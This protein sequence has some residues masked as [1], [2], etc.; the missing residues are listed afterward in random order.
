MD[1]FASPRP[2]APSPTSS[3][4]RSSSSRARARTGSLT[5]ARLRAFFGGSA[6]AELRETRLRSQTHRRQLRAS[7]GVLIEELRV[8]RAR[9]TQLRDDSQAMRASSE[10]MEIEMSRDGTEEWW[11][12]IGEQL[13]LKAM[14]LDLEMRYEESYARKLRGR[15]GRIAML[16]TVITNEAMQDTGAHASE[17]RS[18]FAV[19]AHPGQPPLILKHIGQRPAALRSSKSARGRAMMARSVDA[20]CGTLD[21]VA[22]RDA[23]RRP[24]ALRGSLAAGDDALL[25]I[26]ATLRQVR[27]ELTRVTTAVRHARQTYSAPMRAAEERRRLLA[28]LRAEHGS[29]DADFNALILSASTSLA[30]TLH[31]AVRAVDDVARE[32]LRTVE[33]ASS[34]IQ[35][36]ISSGGA[37]KPTPLAA[38][39][40]RCLRK[41]GSVDQE[42]FV[43]GLTPPSSRRSSDA[44]DE[45]EAMV[46]LARIAASQLEDALPSPPIWE[47]LQRCVDAAVVRIV[48]HFELGDGQ[49][50]GAARSRTLGLGALFDGEAMT[51][52]LRQLVEAA[53]WGWGDGAIGRCCR[54]LAVLGFASWGEFAKEKV[55]ATFR[56]MRHQ[57]LDRARKAAAR[58]GSPRS[59]LV[60]PSPNARRVAS[61]GSGN[62]WSS[63]IEERERFFVQ[64]QRRVRALPPA[65]LGIDCRWRYDP[66]EA[67]VAGSGGGRGSSRLFA[68]ASVLI[69]RALAF[70]EASA[71]ASLPPSLVVEGL[72]DAVRSI[73]DEALSR[74]SLW[75]AYG[76]GGTGGESAAGT[77]GGEGG[78]GGGGG[79]FGADQ[80]FPSICFAL[81]HARVPHALRRLLFASIFA[82]T[83]VG[84]E[85]YVII[86]LRAAVEWVSEHATPRPV[87]R[88]ESAPPSSSRHGVARR[89]TSSGSKSGSAPH[90][91]CTPATPRV[92]SATAML[93]PPR[94][95]GSSAA[96]KR[97][98]RHSLRLGGV[99]GVSPLSAPG[100]G[101]QRE[102]RHPPRLVR[103]ASH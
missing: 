19:T 97:A 52:R 5:G 93:T 35:R 98:A 31:E 94:M 12:L 24:S 57:A 58:K 63:F 15:L 87:A 88:T 28:L 47:M 38:V 11:A 96:G 71:E 82:R 3:S 36:R 62:L 95:G 33:P 54:S 73:N 43:S 2:L 6:E 100:M 89:S 25:A 30:R 60:P 23:R 91:P 81:A 61:H 53:F 55:V 83:G 27:N 75:E 32:T 78:E 10:R 77:G 92:R 65:S 50:G 34:S 90:S 41:V 56:S 99:D 70:D 1:A 16:H 66:A 22:A 13:K 76:S 21:A 68:E 45:S 29:V 69:E 20:A 85:Q 40:L 8:V 49:R 37:P 64:S 48:R 14:V 103:R 7:Y 46:A 102:M 4:A 9:W 67:H 101:R 74:S 80:L 18:A 39:V 51:A 86:S 79:T 59:P 17:V 26:D 72:V 84:E 44:E 42:A